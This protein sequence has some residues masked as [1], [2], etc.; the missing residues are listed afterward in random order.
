MS[1]S[2]EAVPVASLDPST[3]RAMWTL[4]DAHYTGI[5]ENVFVRDL[6][7]KDQALLLWRDGRLVG[8]T[9]HRFVMIDEHRVTYSGDIVI[10]PESRDIG[11]ACFFHR[12]A[13]LMWDRC[14]WWCA[15]SSGPRTHR[16]AHTF[17]RRVTPNE[18][19]DESEEEVR[20][21]HLF[22]R[23]GYGSRYDS[24]RGI[25]RLVDPYTLRDEEAEIRKN[26][27]MDDFFRGAN[28]GWTQGDELVS[29]VRLQPENW[30]PAA[31]R[32]LNWRPAH[33]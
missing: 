19:G 21:R 1:V 28:P 5:S 23:A 10:A 13:R 14:D 2:C 31:M 3:V 30:K 22:A 24:R 9:S 32:M 25:V 18:R 7:A 15:L 4:F 11:S 12:W 6:Q 16:I 26:Y 17:F 33:A 27:P 20:L 29:L 8:F